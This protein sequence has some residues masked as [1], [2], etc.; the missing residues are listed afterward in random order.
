MTWVNQT[1]N[2]KKARR[3]E[4]T[5]HVTTIASNALDSHMLQGFVVPVAA[6]DKQA[7]PE[8]NVS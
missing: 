4:Q 6:R 2:K 3:V 1:S 8:P 7:L 5:G